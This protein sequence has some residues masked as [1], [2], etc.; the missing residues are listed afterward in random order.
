VA[1]PNTQ[2]TKR[3]GVGWQKK[4]KKSDNDGTGQ[5]SQN[6][7]KKT[8]KKQKNKKPNKT[9]VLGRWALNGLP[10]TNVYWLCPQDICDAQ[11]WAKNYRPKFGI[12]TF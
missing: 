3:G 9:K 7:T 10:K 11:K 5:E 2:F 12:P 6:K 1:W 4:K 8:G